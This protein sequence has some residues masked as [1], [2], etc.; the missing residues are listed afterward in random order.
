MPSLSSGMTEELNAQIGRELGAS[1]QYLAMAIHLDAK[2]LRQLARFFYAQAAEEREHAMKFVH[3]MLQADAKPEIP[4]LPR[5][6]EDFDSVEEIAEISLAQEREVTRCIHEL[7]DRALNEKD[8]TTNH[9]LQ[10]FVEEQLEEEATFSEMLD[11]IRQTE[12]LLLVEQ[13]VHR[14]SPGG[15]DE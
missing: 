15:H 10:W 7:V 2:S 1:N 5:P 6:Q 8:H 9:F 4:E 13:Y 11:V 12:N 14:Q 3:Y